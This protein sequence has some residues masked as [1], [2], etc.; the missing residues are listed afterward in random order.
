[1]MEGKA[2]RVNVDMEYSAFSLPKWQYDEIWA[3][4]EEIEDDEEWADDE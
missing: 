4:D 1:M 3:E 2:K